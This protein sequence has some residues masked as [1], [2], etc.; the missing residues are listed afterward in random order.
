MQAKW[1]EPDLG[2]LV[3]IRLFQINNLLCINSLMIRNSDNKNKIPHHSSNIALYRNEL[4][5]AD[6]F[7]QIKNSSCNSDMLHYITLHYTT[8]PGQEWPHRCGCHKIE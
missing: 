6:D 3:Q 8:Q 2:I 5:Y 7:W 1:I 4:I